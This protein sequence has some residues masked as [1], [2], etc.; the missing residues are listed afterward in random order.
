MAAPEEGKLELGFIVK[1]GSRSGGGDLWMN[2]ILKVVLWGFD[3]E[4]KMHG[5]VLRRRKKN[6]QHAHALQCSGF[7]LFNAFSI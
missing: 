2:T 1:F 6:P 7:S 4:I 3:V 5:F